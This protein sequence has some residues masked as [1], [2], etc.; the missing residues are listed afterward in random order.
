[1]INVAAVTTAR[2]RRQFVDL[3]WRLYKDDPNWVPPLRF[4]MINTL[5]PKHNALLN[6]GPWCYFLAYKGKRPVGRVGCG[7]DRRLNEAKGVEAGYITLFECEKDYQVAEALLDAAVGF[8]RRHGA[9]VVTG[10]QSPSNGDDYRGML[11]KGFDTPPTFLSS[12][13]PEWYPEFFERYGFTKQ[14]DRNAYWCDATQPIPERMVRGV[15]IAERRY[16]FRLRTADLKNI[17]KEI[18]VFKHISDNSMPEDWPDM[19]PPSEDE[20]RAEVNKLKFLAISDLIL[21]AEDYEGTPIGMS[22]ALPDYN[23]VLKRMNGRLFPLGWWHFLRARKQIDVARLFVIMVVPEYHRK[24]VSAALY[25]RSMEAAHR[26][27]FRGGD[28]SSI[29]EFNI[30]MNRDAQGAGGVLYKVFRIYQLPI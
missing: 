11:I 24:G 20:V 28:G 1:M 17:E 27:G 13:N 2:Q 8:V 10:P 16:K 14:F 29:H 7:L 22:I 6:L 5:N 18:Q 3:P 30:A 4:D 19:I 23:Q 26:L 25:L 9:T 15:D 21:I 12:Y